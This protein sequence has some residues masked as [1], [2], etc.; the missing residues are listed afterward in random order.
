MDCCAKKTCPAEKKHPESK[1]CRNN[2]CNPFMPCV[3][4]NFYLPVK[5]F[6]DCTI[7]RIKKEK[8]FSFD[9]N[10]LSSIMDDCWHPPE[11]VSN[12]N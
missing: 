2:G 3:Y 9:D 8:V 1:D 6:P 5:N 11:S 4:G 7:I 10:R 12:F